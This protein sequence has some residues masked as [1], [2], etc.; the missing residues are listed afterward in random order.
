MTYKHVIT[1]GV[2]THLEQ[3]Q[4]TY[5]DNGQILSD[6]YHKEITAY[7]TQDT[8]NRTVVTGLAPVQTRDRII[9]DGTVNYNSFGQVESAEIKRTVITEQSS[10][11]NGRDRSVSGKRQMTTEYNDNRG[12]GTVGST[13][14]W[15]AIIEY[16]MDISITTTQDTSGRVA[17][18]TETT[19]INGWA[20]VGAALVPARDYYD[21]VTIT[22]ER[23][24]EYSGSSAAPTGWT[25]TITRSDQALVIERS[26]SDVKYNSNGQMTEYRE[27]ENRHGEFT[28]KDGNTQRIDVTTE[29]YRYDMRYNSDN[30]TSEYKE[31]RRSSATPGLIEYSEVTNIEYNALGQITGYAEILYQYGVSDVGATPAWPVGGILDKNLVDKCVQITGELIANNPEIK[32]VLNRRTEIIRSDIT[33]NARGQITGYMDEI[34]NSDGS[35]ERVTMSEI[36]YLPTGEM[37]AYIEVRETWSADGELTPIT[38]RGPPDTTIETK[39]TSITYD[40]LGRISEKAGT[41][42]G[43]SY[44]YKARA[45]D[46]LGR[47]TVYQEKF[48]D[49]KQK[50]II[51]T[52]DATGRVTGETIE[53]TAK[54]GTG[55]FESKTEIG[56][57][58]EYSY[59]INGTRD[60]TLE[61]ELYHKTSSS[62]IGTIVK[63][64]VGIVTAIV[65]FGAGVPFVAAAVLALENFVFNMLSGVDPG[66]AAIMAAISFAATL[67]GA[68]I[69]GFLSGGMEGL[70]AVFTASGT[71]TGTFAE[72]ITGFFTEYSAFGFV[73]QALSLVDQFMVDDK[74]RGLFEQVFGEWGAVVF[75]AISIIGGMM[76]SAIGNHSPPSQY[77]IFGALGR[78]ITLSIL[79]A[80]GDRINPYLKQFLSGFFSQ[81]FVTY[82]NMETVQK[83]H[84]AVLEAQ[85]FEV[86][87]DFWGNVTEV[88]PKAIAGFGNAINN[89]IA[90][91]GLSTLVNATNAVS[92]FALQKDQQGFWGN[93]KDGVS[94]MKDFSEYLAEEFGIGLYEGSELAKELFNDIAFLE[95]LSREGCFEGF[96]LS[97]IDQSTDT[98][99]AIYKAVER[100]KTEKVYLINLLNEGVVQLLGDKG[101]PN[102]DLPGEFEVNGNKFEI[103]YTNGVWNKEIGAH[104]SRN[105]L[106]DGINQF[107]KELNIF[108]EAKVGYIHNNTDG[109][110]DLGQALTEYLGMTDDA[111]LFKAYYINERMKADPNFT[112]ILT[113]HSQGGLK[114]NRTWDFIDSQFKDRI[115][116]ITNGGAQIGGYSDAAAVIN[117]I[118]VGDIVP[119]SS[120]IKLNYN[121]PNNEYYVTIPVDSWV[122]HVPGVGLT[123]H[124]YVPNYNNINAQII[125]NILTLYPNEDLKSIIKD[126]DYENY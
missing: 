126:L 106:G 28:D 63:A 109:I 89:S 41:I 36:K 33:Y 49:V 102:H 23:T 123:N 57:K 62:P 65:T 30:L 56:T 60:T 124:T 78:M 80:L 94:V 40:Q 75:G 96:D 115:Y 111:A 86:E 116:V 48:D 108:E 77:Q 67:A 101:I 14:A 5:S 44:H 16:T 42:D 45:F 1:D 119:F 59:D 83:K 71:F 81:M 76:S 43:E 13:P 79:T 103:I 68:A 92:R 12:T 18:E 4:Y 104:K 6:T 69:G 98:G 74:G 38:E 88:I 110:R 54:K 37:C 90:T 55:I 97:T 15:T 84:I 100:L 35:F 11:G 120:I 24:Y 95:V 27:T 46:T 26:V 61:K 47:A 125:T 9:E 105:N 117:I 52:F 122:E 113:A 91:G 107:L 7:S 34:T 21:N 66:K 85:G 50:H 121:L 39:I 53:I 25:D 112:M 58:Y 99:K 82:G 72:R 51:E 10:V 29:R 31:I 32:G 114:D 64:V 22:R 118:K 87:T 8:E 70:Q 3:H 73:M 20:S 2:M 19:V 17:T 93:L